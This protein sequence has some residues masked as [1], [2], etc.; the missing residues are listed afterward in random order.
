MDLSPSC[1]PPVNASLKEEDAK[2]PRYP[3]YLKYR[4][5]MS[6]QLVSCNS[7]ENWLHQVE[8][9]ELADQ[10]NHHY[11]IGEFRAWLRENVNCTPQ[12]V[13]YLDFWAWLEHNL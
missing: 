8:R 11:R 7:F 4:S 1:L 5:A 6:A 9:A 10:A 2:H 12:K 13:A 3:E